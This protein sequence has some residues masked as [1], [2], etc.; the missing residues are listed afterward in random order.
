MLAIG[1]G[2]LIGVVIGALGGG[3]GVL[4]VPLL[5]HVLGQSAQDAT[6]SS[7]VIVGV[8]AT[9]GVLVRIRAGKIRWRTA[10]GFGAVGLPAAALGTLVNQRVAEPVLLLAFAG[11]TLLAA[12]AMIFD[13]WAGPADPE[14]TGGGGLA[15]AAPPTVRATA[16]KI[17]ACG[18]VTGFLTGFL[19]VGGGFLVVPAL[20]IVLRV[21]IA[22]AAGT[23]LVIISLNSAAALASRAG[24][25]DL[26]WGVIIPFTLAAVL[27]SVAGTRIADRCSSAALTRAFA[28]LLLAVGIYVGFTAL[29]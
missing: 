22:W 17:V 3:G 25:I 27:G 9:A 8:T 23:S 19:G 16:A 7:V 4:A 11:L 10:L 20:V 18:A 24:A 29:A 14:P 28:L 1:L 13:E 21:P 5:V 2:L 6:T 15:L 26:D 12:L